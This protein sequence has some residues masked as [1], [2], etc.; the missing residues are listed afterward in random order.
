M[1]DFEGGED[2][3]EEDEEEEEGADSDASPLRHG[4]FLP[5]LTAE[6]SN[7]RFSAK[8]VVDDFEDSPL[9]ALVASPGSITTSG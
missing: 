2:D 8:E 5:P 3:E 9:G 1:D 6:V 4:F 7:L